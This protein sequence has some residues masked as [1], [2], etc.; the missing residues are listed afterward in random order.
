MSAS[1]DIRI[2]KNRN[3][4]NEPEP[5]T[6]TSFWMNCNAPEF[7]AVSRTNMCPSVRPNEKKSLSGICFVSQ[8]MLDHLT[9]VFII[10]KDSDLF[11]R[12]FLQQFA[13]Y[14]IYKFMNLLALFDTE[15]IRNKLFFEPCSQSKNQNWQFHIFS[16]N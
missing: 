12:H 13:T 11:I 3:R 15:Q 2:D 10:W 7:R 8:F 14:K 6:S 5:S 1:N 16:I 9:T 4:E